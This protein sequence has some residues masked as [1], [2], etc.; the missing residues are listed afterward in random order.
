M[1]VGRAGLGQ[2]TT[3]AHHASKHK[4]DKTMVYGHRQENSVQLS[5]PLETPT[6][7]GLNGGGL[8]WNLSRLGA[9]PFASHYGTCKLGIIEGKFARN[10]PL[11]N[12][13]NLLYAFDSRLE[14]A[15]TCTP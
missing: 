4:H 3:W 9:G 6:N 12:M 15:I 13:S 2:E 7:F 11:E 5:K 14:R 1:K 10:L 8:L